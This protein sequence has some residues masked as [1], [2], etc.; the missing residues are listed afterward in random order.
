[1]MHINDTTRLPKG[2]HLT[3][4]ERIEI[5]TFKRM[6]ESNRFIAKVLG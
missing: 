3:M 2:Q 1:M 6:G 5:Q 4:I